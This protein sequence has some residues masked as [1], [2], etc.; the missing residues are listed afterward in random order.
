MTSPKPGTSADFPAAGNTRPTGTANPAPAQ[1]VAADGRSRVAATDRP[2]VHAE[3]AAPSI[4]LRLAH[5][6]VAGGLAA[7]R[8]LA[9]LT[10]AAEAPPVPA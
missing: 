2:T 5:R 7:R 9:Q 6:P 4:P 1:A 10:R 8:M 3:Y